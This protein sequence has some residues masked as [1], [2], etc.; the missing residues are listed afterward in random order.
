MVTQLKEKLEET[1]A[2]V[3]RELPYNIKAEQV[4][5]GNLMVNNDDLNKVADFLTK[6][7]FYEPIHQEIRP[8]QRRKK[9]SPDATR[10]SN[11]PDPYEL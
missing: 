1:M 8:L 7:H 4:L 2:S 5:L 11:P 9:A 10:S 6:D 3:K